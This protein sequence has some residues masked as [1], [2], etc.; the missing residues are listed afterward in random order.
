MCFE[1]FLSVDC[2]NRKQQTG[3]LRKNKKKKKR[4]KNKQNILEAGISRQGQVANNEDDLFLTCRH[5]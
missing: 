3:S 2:Y 4:R 5:L 1:I